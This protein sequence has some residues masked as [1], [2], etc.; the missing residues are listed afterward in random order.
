MSRQRLQLG[1]TQKS[2]KGMAQGYSLNMVW[3]V[4]VA[5]FIFSSFFFF[6]GFFSGGR[7]LTER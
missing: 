5:T 2:A 4:T 7:A 1:K 3:F 6:F